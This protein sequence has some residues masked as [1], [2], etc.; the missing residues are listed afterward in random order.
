MQKQALRIVFQ[1]EEKPLLKGGISINRECIDLIA[2][3]LTNCA[4]SE[5]ETILVT[6]GAIASGVEKLSL[7][8]YP[9]SLTEKQAIAAIG[10]V[11]LI[12]RYQNIFDEYNQMIGQVLLDR[13]VIDNPKRKLNAQNTFKRLLELRVIPVINENDTTSTD[14]IEQENNYPLTHAVAEIAMAHVLVILNDDNSFKLIQ[15]KEKVVKNFKNKN[16]LFSYL[17]KMDTDKIIPG[18]FP[19]SFELSQFKITEYIDSN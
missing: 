15:S 7:C 18:D 3:V 2:M 1:V 6:A 16:V 12:R 10:Q 17:N 11:E 8:K 13:N 4:N 14:D 5:K 9:Q 19:D